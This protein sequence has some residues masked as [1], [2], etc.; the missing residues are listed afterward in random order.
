MTDC[1]VVAIRNGGA[2]TINPDP[3]VTIREGDEMIVIGTDEGE[4]NFCLPSNPKR[5]G[6]F[7]DFE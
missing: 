4:R 7:P 5:P 6:A 2:M 3:E 1:S